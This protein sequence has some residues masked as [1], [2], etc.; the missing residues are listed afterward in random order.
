[1]T[2]QPI[3]YPAGQIRSLDMMIPRVART[4]GIG[5]TRKAGARRSRAFLPGNRLVGSGQV[6]LQEACRRG[7]VKSAK[8]LP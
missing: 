2:D 1:M 3:A 8:A 7:F 4:M 6:R 5:A